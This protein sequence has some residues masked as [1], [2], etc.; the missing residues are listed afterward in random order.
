MRWCVSSWDTINA[1]VAPTVG[2]AK[3]SR[4]CRLSRQR[5]WFVPARRP[6][7]RLPSWLCGR[8]YSRANLEFRSR[9]EIQREYGRVENFLNSDARPLGV[10]TDD[11]EMALALSVSLIERGAL[12]PK[13]CAATYAR[14]FD[15]E[16]RRGY[17]PAVSKILAM[18]YAEG[19]YRDTGRAVYAEGSFGN[20]GAMR[21]APV[22]LAFRNAGDAVL[23]EAVGSAL[24]CT[25][26][27][28]DAVDGAFIQAK[29]V[30]ALALDQRRHQP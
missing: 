11:T 8:R 6:V 19:D 30:A 23:R 27:H 4:F 18:L 7:H 12:N 9:A 10:F 28:P 25:H 14:F 3:P 26:V 22:G 15:A 17:G 20:G 29:A 21:I 2:H 1:M 16:P 24:L 5:R 13:H